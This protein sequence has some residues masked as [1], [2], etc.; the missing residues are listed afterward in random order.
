MKRFIIKILLWLLPIIVLAVSTEFLLRQIPN[1]YSY[2]KNY[3]DKHS[4]KIQ[5]LILG[6]SNSVYGINPAFFSQ[7]AFNAGNVSQTLNFD[8]KIFNKYK[9][10]FNDL[11][12]IIIPISYPA[13]WSKLETGVE[14]WRVNNYTIYY[15]MNPNA[16]SDYS[17][18]LTHSL[19][20]NFKRLYK[21]YFEKENDIFCSELG[22]ESVYISGYYF[23]H[24][25]EKNG[26]KALSQAADIHSEGAMKVFAEN[27]QV[28]NSFEEFCI[29]KNIKLIFLTTPAY[30]S[31]REN[32]N[33]E[34]FNKVVDTMNDIVAKHSNC[35]YLNCIEDPDFTKEDYYDADHLNG[36]GAEK[37][38]KKLALYVDSLMISNK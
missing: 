28:L 38:S 11:R 14:S 29:R 2:K 35:Y 25:L 17:E 15:G 3:L 23:G 34:Q 8:Y 6:S 4:E 16:L 37:L 33:M 7:R 13:L 31:F 19:S 1:D 27:M 9:D 12:V 10:K 22:W 36:C 24:D 21:Y 18:F 20:I 32:L 26:I 30:H 5:I